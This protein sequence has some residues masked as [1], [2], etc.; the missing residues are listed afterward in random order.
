MSGFGEVTMSTITRLRN[1]WRNI[2]HRGRV[3]RDLD[4]ERRSVF[5]QLVAEKTHAGMAP[6]EARRQ[7]TL[8]MGRLE[9]VKAQVR[10]NR[11]GA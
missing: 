4:D 6:A 1:L 2:V 8:E 7:T 5:E 11:S 9:S 10:E 3:E